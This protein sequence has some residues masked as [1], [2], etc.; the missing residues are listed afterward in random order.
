MPKAYHGLVELNDRAIRRWGE[1]RSLC[2]EDHKG[3][4][5]DRIRRM[6]EEIENEILSW[7]EQMDSIP[8]PGE[9]VDPKSVV[10][11]SVAAVSLSN[12]KEELYHLREILIREELRHM[13]SEYIHNRIDEIE[14]ML[15]QNS[16][17]LERIVLGGQNMMKITSF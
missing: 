4:P 12:L 6:K 15:R 10:I 17:E 1:V 2:K 13:D 5:L 14:Q 16:N 3:K 11:A 9:K 7:R 8:K